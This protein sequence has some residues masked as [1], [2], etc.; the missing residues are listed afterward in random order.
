MAFHA[1]DH[2]VRARSSEGVDRAIA[3][4]HLT[5]QSRPLR[6]QSIRAVMLA[7][8]LLLGAGA[9][10]TPAFAEAGAEDHGWSRD[11]DHDGIYA[12]QHWD[13]PCVLSP[14][15]GSGTIPAT[16]PGYFDP[17]GKGSIRHHY[18]PARRGKLR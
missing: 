4:Q 6:G 17:S 1:D 18:L 7:S 16:L 9:I 8:F 2:E 15:C 14:A 13:I 5:R 3:I 11:G 10:A 12:L